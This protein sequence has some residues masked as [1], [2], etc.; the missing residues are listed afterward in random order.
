MKTLLCLIIT[1]FL[2]VSAADKPTVRA[3]LGELVEKIQAKLKDKKTKEAD[4]TAELKAFDQILEDHKGEKSDDMAQVLYMKSLLYAQVFE[5]SEKAVVLMT[6]LQKDFPES[7]QAKNAEKIIASMER[8]ATAAKISKSL[9]VGNSFPDFKEK[10]LDGKPLSVSQYKGKVLLVDF[11]ATWCPPCRAELPNVLKTYATYHDKGFEIVGISLDNDEQTLRDFL[12]KNKMP[13]QQ[14]FDGKGWESKLTGVY[15]VTAI[16]A[17][18]LLDTE[19][20]IVGQG[21]RGED[22]E[23]AVAKLVKK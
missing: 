11:W 10:D 23:A 16:P 12:K 15:G 9:V 7:S 6:K 19:G 13:W 8:Q 22:L 5:D 18:Y 20:K 3:E 17:T 2:S 4:F 1:A 21:L 14:Y